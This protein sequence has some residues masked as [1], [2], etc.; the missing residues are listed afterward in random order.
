MAEGIRK[1]GEKYSFRIN[2][3]DPLTDKWKN[4]ERSGFTTITEAK[5]ARTKLLAE[6]ETTPSKIIIKDKSVSLSQVY[7]E[8]INKY[9]VYDREKSTLTK[10]G[11]V[12]KNHLEPNWGNVKMGKVTYKELSE[13][14]FSLSHT[15]SNTYI[16][17]ILKFMKVLWKFAYEQ[18]YLKENIISKV[19]APKPDTEETA[20]KIYTE[21]ELNRFQ[22]RFSSTNLYTSFM[23]ARYTG[24]RRSEVYGLLWSDIDWVNHTL[25]INKQL[26]YEDKMWVLRNLKT[27]AAI[28][29]IDLPDCLYQHLKDL[30]EKQQQSKSEYGVAYKVNRIAIDNGRNKPKTI[31][32]DL[33]FINIK[34]DG[35]ALT[36]H[37]ER[38]LSRIAEKEFDI[39]FKFH[40][41]RHS[42]ASWLAEHNIPAVVAKERLGH[43]TEEV[44]LKYYHHVTEGMRENLVN[45]LNSQGHIEGNSDL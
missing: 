40:N 28:R 25:S 16:V 23:I 3:K 2:V 14:L 26:I 11:T 10:Y 15:H 20:I 35:T 4:I 8:F 17:S 6:L 5:K 7:H 41:L 21:Q 27:K 42:H 22:E 45:L 30:R 34:P 9:A 36:S 32:E 43:A 29:T 38:V 31:V 1:R 24:C 33:E 18:E 39:G 12:Y 19:T 37:S 13:Y 44:T